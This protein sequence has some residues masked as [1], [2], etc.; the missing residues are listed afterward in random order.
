[1]TVMEVHRPPVI[2]R[3][4]TSLAGWAPRPVIVIGISAADTTAAHTRPRKKYATV[5]DALSVR[6][7]YDRAPL[8]YGFSIALMI[9]FTG[10]GTPCAAA[11]STSLPPS[12]GSSSRRPAQI[13]TA[14][15]G[16]QSVGAGTTI[17][18]LDP[19]ARGSR[20]PQSCTALARRRRRA[21]GF[22][23]RVCHLVR[24]IARKPTRQRHRRGASGD[25]RSRPR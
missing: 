12:Q 14:I 4:E 16:I 5:K 8:A 25:H 6:E 21:A 17:A 19:T 13:S 2:T 3:R 11:S 9:R 1:M 24:R 7:G 22:T 10:T 18:G 23:G 15:D 20:P